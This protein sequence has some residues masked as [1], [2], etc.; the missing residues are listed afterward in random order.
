MAVWPDDSNRYGLRGINPLVSFRVTGSRLPS[1]A[2]SRPTTALDM[3]ARFAKGEAGIFRS[4][5]L[6]AEITIAPFI[7]NHHGAFQVR[8]RGSPVSEWLLHGG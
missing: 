6:D 2:A 5:V 8:L 1:Q 4:K 3:Q 7:E